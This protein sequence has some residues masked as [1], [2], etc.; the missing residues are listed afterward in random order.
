MDEIDL[1]RLRKFDK[2]EKMQ[3][4]CQEKNWTAGKIENTG[5]VLQGMQMMATGRLDPKERQICLTFLDIYYQQNIIS[6]VSTL[7]FNQKLI[8]LLSTLTSNHTR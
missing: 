1:I 4:V 6:L 8:S 2:V 5:P 3:N 7:T